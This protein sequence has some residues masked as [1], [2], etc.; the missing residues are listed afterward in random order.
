MRIVNLASGSKANSTFV[1]YGLSKMLID[2]GLNEKQLISRLESIGE[3]IKNILG[4]CIT[5]EHIDHIRGVK[6]LAKKY[7]FDFYIKRELAESDFFK[8]VTFKAGKLHKID[9]EKFVIGE[10]EITPF[11]V[12]HD[13]IAPVAYVVNVSGSASKVGFITDVGVVSENVKKHLKNTKM[14]FI[15]SNYDEQ[16]LYNG[17]YPYIVKKR[18][19]SEKGHLSNIQSLELAKFLFENG[20][21]CFVLSHLSQNNNTPEIAYSNYATYFEK[22]GIILDKEVFVR[23]SHQDKHGN[24]FNLKEDF[25]GK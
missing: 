16:M 23:I 9:M 21:K 11:E 2:V 17:K 20:T 1:E 13:A 10:L 24:N 7:D 4:I 3:D 18:I 5:H 6:T 22:Q 25:N 15:E 12:S 8:D 14:V 19:D